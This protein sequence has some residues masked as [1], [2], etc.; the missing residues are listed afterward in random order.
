MTKSQWPMN[1]NGAVQPQSTPSAQRNPR[2]VH[3]LPGTQPPGRTG[4]FLV[5]SFSAYPESLYL[6]AVLACLPR[7]VR[8]RQASFAVK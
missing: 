1:P 6:V 8:R 2:V 5:G 7:R 3:A 4:Q